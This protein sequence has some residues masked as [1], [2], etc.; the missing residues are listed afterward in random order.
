MPFPGKNLFLQTTRGQGGVSLTPGMCGHLMPQLQLGRAWTIR[1]CW[2]LQPCSCH[3]SKC[4]RGRGERNHRTHNSSVQEPSVNPRSS[5]SQSQP[6][7][8]R[9]PFQGLLHN[10]RLSCSSFSL[11]G[12]SRFYPEIFWKRG[13]KEIPSLS[14]RYF[15]AHLLTLH[16]RQG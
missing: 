5:N 14:V 15:Q 6:V 8:F 16:R 12:R 3:L 4:S 9:K 7:T 1:L 2:R 10:E 11:T 13:K